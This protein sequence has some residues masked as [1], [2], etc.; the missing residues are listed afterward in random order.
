MSIEDIT[1]NTLEGCLGQEANVKRDDRNWAEY[2]KD[3][4]SETT[5]RFGQ[6]TEKAGQR[7]EDSGSEYQ[8]QE[9]QRRAQEV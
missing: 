5:K 2:T 3:K 9:G 7:I 4:L 8:R 6:S 1:K